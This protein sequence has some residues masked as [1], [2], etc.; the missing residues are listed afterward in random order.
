MK[1]EVGPYHPRQPLGTERKQA[2]LKVLAQT[3][4]F[5]AAARAASPHTPTGA[6]GTFSDEAKREPKFAA[7]IEEAKQAYASVVLAELHRRS[8][9]GYDEPVFSGKGFRSV[10]HDGRPASVRKYSDRLMEVALRNSYIFGSTFAQNSKVEMDGK[11]THQSTTPQLTITESE[12]HRLSSDQRRALIPI[13]RSI[14]ELKKTP[15]EEIEAQE[16]QMLAHDTL[17]EFEDIDVELEDWEK[18]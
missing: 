14:A 16:A 9:E 4:S 5:S 6:L 7:A 8:V 3:G 1:H 15:E 2:F 13:L 10:D 17:A 12:I 18:L 11:I